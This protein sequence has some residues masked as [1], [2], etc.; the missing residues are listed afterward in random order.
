[1]RIRKL[2]FAVSVMAVSIA[3]GSSPAN[4]QA[5]SPTQGPVKITLDDAIQ[6][7]LAHNHTLAAARSTIQQSEAQEITANLR[8]DPVLLGD[9][10][11]LPLFHPDQASAD[12]VNSAAQFDLGVSYLFERGKKRQHRLAAAKDQTAV[13]R[14]QVADNERSLAFQVAT[15]FTNAQLAESVLDLA[16]QDLKSFRN[17]VDISK[18]RYRAGDIS[19]G[20][21]LKIKLQL[22]QF[23]ADASQAKLARVQALSDLR[24]L[25]GRESVPLD[26]DVAG[27][28]DYQPLSAK[29]EDLQ[30]KALA[31]RPDLRAAQ[32]GVTTANSQYE[33]AKADGKRDVTAQISYTHTAAVSTASLFGQV[34]LPIFD[35]NQG[36]IAR[37]HFAIT[38]AQEQEKAASDQVLTDVEDAY[39]GLQS[40]DQ[41]IQ[42]YRSGYL[43]EAKQDRDISEYA[44]KRGAASLLDFLDAE[45]SYRA[46]ELAYRQS[47]AA[48]LL[49]LEQLR[50]AVGTRSLP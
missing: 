47:L 24:Q 37:T 33:L 42:L 38:Q 11:F 16:E 30:V 49:A 13:T 4:A 14:S 39:E 23:Q 20:D 44:Y 36:E 12:Y 25:L 6:M 3:A 32:Q 50:E 18:E 21:Y 29:M 35:R 8:P 19:E 17:T 26:Y 48:Y 28:F 43:D 5:T 46:T 22:L 1:M 41:I 15:L 27:A 2:H 10:Q 9:A 34:Q 40:N 45:R 7:A 31:T